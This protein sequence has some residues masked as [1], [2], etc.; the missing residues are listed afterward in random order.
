MNI[1]SFKGLSARGFTR[2]ATAIL[3]IH[4]MGC[5][6]LSRIES[7]LFKNS[8]LSNLNPA[9]E[10][11]SPPEFRD[12]NGPIV[13]NVYM[14]SQADYHFTM[15][16]AYSLEGLS[17]KAIEEF[18]LTLVYDPASAMVRMRL[19]AE[20]IR[21]GLLSEAIEQTEAAVEADPDSV[22][23]KMLLGG[24]YS[25]LKMYEQALKQYKAI[26]DIDPENVDAPIFIGAILAEKDQLSDAII[27]FKSLA[28]NKK[29]KEP[30]K[31]WYYVGRI[32]LEK[33]QKNSVSN[34]KKAY[35][36]SISLQPSY[37][38]SVLAL[39]T[40]YESQ[41]EK[42][43]ALKL[44]ESFQEKFGPSREVAK[45]LSRIY[46]EG[47]DYDKAFSQLEV[48]EGYERSNLNVKLQMALIM[49]EQKR[50]QEAAIR[51]EDILVE[52]PES[53][54][55]RYYLGAV[56][57]ELDEYGDAL[58]HFQRVPSSSIYY[59]EAVILSANILKEQSG[60]EKAADMVKEAIGFRD[61]IPQFYAFYAALLD[62]LK[63][64][65][66]AITMLNNAVA[67]FPSHT[68]LRFFLGSMHDRVGDTSKTIEHMKKVLEIDGNHVQAMNYLAYTYA[69]ANMN[70]ED[71]ESLARKALA[72]K[73]EDGYI[74]DT[75]GWIMYKRG[76]IEG[77]VKY[78]EAAYRINSQ[79]SV[80]AE[81]LADVYTQK[82]LIDKAVKLYRKAL[83]LET[84]TQKIQ[85]LQK[86]ITSLENQDIRR[87]RLP[88]SSDKPKPIR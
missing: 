69:E 13:D 86:K 46:L 88:A 80:I 53:D 74:L 44:L 56:Y 64:Y 39:G 32:H 59:P 28:E 57:E 30:W 61:D 72:A 40:L 85:T 78:L 35:M 81:H 41:N 83:E 76:D 45:Q 87:G 42:K 16:E 6:S 65:S 84:D 58:K 24:L 73:P 5:S 33:D 51:L 1:N 8:T 38:E 26:L 54:K 60:N 19:A 17:E 48:V 70:L 75:V 27:Y 71:A 67:K 66:Q 62:E 25:S 63:E 55:I 77:A 23:A 11:M 43:K 4:L 50:Y 15:G 68:Q 20:F 29:Y 10:S 9:P 47:Q 2:L 31:A 49:I 21:Q 52:A 37:A 3:S 18:K 36:K 12:E 7:A 22:D 14:R 82:E 34:A 79:E